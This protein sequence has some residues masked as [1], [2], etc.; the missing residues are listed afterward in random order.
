MDFISRFAHGLQRVATSPLEQRAPPLAVPLLQ[1]GLCAMSQRGKRR[2]T[3]RGF[4]PTTASATA[5][6]LTGSCCFVLGFFCW[7]LGLPEEVSRNDRQG[8]AITRG[9]FSLV[10]VARGRHATRSVALV[11]WCVV[12]VKSFAVRFQTE[13]EANIFP[14]S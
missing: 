2:I 7:L 14:H 11:F 13:A 1:H 9:P 6:V 3:Q 4:A 12:A 5:S 8:V 10:G